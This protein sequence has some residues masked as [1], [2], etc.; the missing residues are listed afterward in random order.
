MK[1]TIIPIDQKVNKD[2]LAYWPLDLSQCSIPNDV[3]ALQWE[4]T[5]GWIEYEDTRPND[6]ITELPQWALNCEAVW[7]IA[8]DA[9]HSV[10]PPIIE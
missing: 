8:Y 2:G 7:Q 1:L 10:D 5:Q 9:D 3:H 4:N 6:P